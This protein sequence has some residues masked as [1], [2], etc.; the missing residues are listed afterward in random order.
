MLMALLVDEC[1]WGYYPLP[2]YALTSSHRRLTLSGTVLFTFLHPMD[3]EVD[4][5][6]L[7][8]TNKLVHDVSLPVDPVYEHGLNNSPAWCYVI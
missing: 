6:P 5:Q 1:Q 8:F 4:R 7:V 3:V 2:S